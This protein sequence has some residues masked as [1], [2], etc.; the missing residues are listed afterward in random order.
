MSVVVTNAR[1]RIAYNVV[2]SLGQR[3]VP[4]YVADSVSRPMSA[5]SRYASGHFTYPSPFHDPEGFIECLATEL[6]RLGADVLIPV[7]EETFLIARHKARLSPLVSMAVPDYDQILTAHNKDKWELVARRLGIPVPAAYS[8]E[9]LRGGGVGASQPRFPVLIKPKQGGGAWGIR[10]APSR[11]ALEQLLDQPTWD[12]KSWDRFFVQEK[13]EGETHCVAMLFNRGQLRAKVAYRQLRDFPTTGG[14]AT[15]RVSLRSET[16]ERY[17]QQLLEDLR[18]HGPCQADF[19]VD[20]QTGLPYLI[21][22]NPRLWGSL[23]QAIASGVDFPYLIYRMAKDGDVPPVVSFKT[24]VVTRWL[25]GDIAALPARLRS[26]SEKL[27]VLR[28]F[29]FPA[30][31]AV[32]FD[33]FSWSDPLPMVHWCADAIVRA[34]KF[35]STAAVSHD[36]LQGTWE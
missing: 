26:S 28:D 15:V 13:V 27:T 29:L 19:I 34:V 12:G 2:R 31:P 32:L 9:A 24:G 33:D 5:A 3:G 21:D 20:R 35:R 7:F 6:P 30:T 8:P 23:V 16:A 1:N 18:W 36:S 17:L 22:V 4:V 25:G 14:Q 10:E 11:A